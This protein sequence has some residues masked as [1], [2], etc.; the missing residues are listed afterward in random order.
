MPQICR[1]DNRL[2][3][4][5]ALLTG[6]A[7]A[8]GLH[9]MALWKDTWDSGRF[10][11]NPSAM[12]HGLWMMSIQAYKLSHWFWLICS[13]SSPGLSWAAKYIWTLFRQCFHPRLWAN[14]F[15]YPA[16]CELLDFYCLNETFFSFIPWHFLPDPWKEEWQ[17][18]DVNT[19]LVLSPHWGCNSSAANAKP[20]YGI[21]VA[22]DCCITLKGCWNSSILP[23][24]FQGETSVKCLWIYIPKNLP[25][26]WPAYT[27]HCTALLF[28]KGL[29][30]LVT[31][32]ISYA[33]KRIRIYLW[34]ICGKSKFWF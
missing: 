19:A 25:F 28:C 23:Y 1:Q 34:N 9:T 8:A 5:A 6:G 26:F 22:S 27:E 14:V 29:S 31:E 11:A 33:I 13:I 17:Q 20:L 7:R 24:F 10:A 18:F 2:H 16:K 3:A 15:G 12:D 4:A 21:Q 30:V 32:Y